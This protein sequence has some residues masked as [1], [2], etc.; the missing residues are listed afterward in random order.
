MGIRTTRSRAPRSTTGRASIPTTRRRTVVMRTAAAWGAAADGGGTT[1][2]QMKRTPDLS[3]VPYRSLFEPWGYWQRF[4]KPNALGTQL[5]KEL[6]RLSTR[7]FKPE[8]V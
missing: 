2:T 6:F 3:G 8:M 5:S 4:A 1:G 7:L